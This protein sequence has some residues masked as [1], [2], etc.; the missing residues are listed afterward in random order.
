ME[1]CRPNALNMFTTH[2]SRDV[3]PKQHLEV[4]RMSSTLS[5]AVFAM[6]ASFFFKTYFDRTKNN[7]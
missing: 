3:M 4:V 5:R 2:A 7:M 1:Y 6:I